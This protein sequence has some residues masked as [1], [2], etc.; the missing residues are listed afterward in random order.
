MWFN[1]LLL[2]ALNYQRAQENKRSETMTC[3]DS[4]ANTLE[5][6]KRDN[7]I[8]TTYVPI[9]QINVQLKQMF[10]VVNPILLKDIW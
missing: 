5:L 9:G 8:N 4:T 10:W 1:I 2:C 7:A 6:C 3:S